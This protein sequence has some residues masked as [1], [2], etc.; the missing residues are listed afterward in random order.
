[1]PTLLSD[2][3]CW[4]AKAENI[5]SQRVFR[6]LTPQQT[7]GA[8]LPLDHDLSRTLADDR[9]LKKWD[10]SSVAKLHYCDGSIADCAPRTQNSASAR[11]RSHSCNSASIRD[12]PEVILSVGFRRALMDAPKA[13]ETAIIKKICWRILPLVLVAYCVAYVDRANIAVAALTGYGTASSCRKS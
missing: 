8:H 9:P 3:R 1:M 5:C 7:S 11:D 4:G 12:L 10:S 2:V 13:F 6:L